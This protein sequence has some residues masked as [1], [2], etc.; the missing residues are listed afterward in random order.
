M[1]LEAAH[2]EIQVETADAQIKLY[3]TNFQP[4]RLILQ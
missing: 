2:F 1:M 4:G 3:I